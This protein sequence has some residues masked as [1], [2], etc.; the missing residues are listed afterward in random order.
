MLARHSTG[1]RRTVQR[2]Q[3]MPGEEDLFECHRDHV[4]RVLLHDKQ[5]KRCRS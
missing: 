4:T 5:K 3:G 1:T 2:P